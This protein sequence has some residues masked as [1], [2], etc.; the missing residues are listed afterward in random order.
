MSKIPAHI[1]GKSPPGKAPWQ[2]LLKDAGEDRVCPSTGSSSMNSKTQGHRQVWPKA[3]RG[4][5]HLRGTHV[6]P[7]ALETRT[8][9][10]GAAFTVSRGKHG[11]PTCQALG[12]STQNTTQLYQDRALPSWCLDAGWQKADIGRRGRNSRQRGLA[13]KTGRQSFTSTQ[14]R[15][16]G[17]TGAQAGGGWKSSVRKGRGQDAA[18]IEPWNAGLRSPGFN[19]S[20][21]I[22]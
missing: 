9:F 5:G 1:Y 20:N 21:R 19:W 17:S 13:A 2:A 16:H 18:D 11:A 12:L 15:A 4:N 6:E 8:G 10:G 7:A 3:G 14:E 22:T